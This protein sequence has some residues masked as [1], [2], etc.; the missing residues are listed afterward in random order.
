MSRLNYKIKQK[1]APMKHRSFGLTK[2]KKD[3]TNF[4]SIKYS[5]I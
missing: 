3:Y 5:A 4:L 2:I 1:K